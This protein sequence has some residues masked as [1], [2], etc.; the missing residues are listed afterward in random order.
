VVK[1][2]VKNGDDWVEVGEANQLLC[3]IVKEFKPVFLD[4]YES[5]IAY[6]FVH[7]EFTLCLEIKMPAEAFRLLHEMAG[8]T[9]MI[10]HT[11]F[12]KL[13][14]KGVTFEREDLPELDARGKALLE[15]FNLLEEPSEEEVGRREDL[16]DGH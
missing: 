10:N 8:G 16:L 15:E 3:E 13:E 7:Q 9:I 4:N 1:I 2:G 14:K 6:D 12:D 11:M 5:P